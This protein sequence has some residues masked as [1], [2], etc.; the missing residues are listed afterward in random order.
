MYFKQEHKILIS[1]ILIV[2][3]LGIIINKHSLNILTKKDASIG[4]VLS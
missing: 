4:I 3:A 2:V 1:K